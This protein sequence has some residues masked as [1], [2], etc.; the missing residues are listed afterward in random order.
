[1]SEEF[2]KIGVNKA[3]NSKG[4]SVQIKP[5]GGILYCDADGDTSIDSEWLVKPPRILL[6]K[7]NF[8]MEQSRVENMFS[9]VVKALEFLGHKVEIWSTPSGLD[10]K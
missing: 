10:K 6:Y 8:E 1:M 4:F 5:M 9:N 3:V 7:M 2:T